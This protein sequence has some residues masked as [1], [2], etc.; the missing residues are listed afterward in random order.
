MPKTLTV[1]VTTNSD[2]IDI[3][4]SAIQAMTGA[5]RRKPESTIDPSKGSIAA[6]VK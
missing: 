3:L 2:F 5:K 4:E 6:P 1:P